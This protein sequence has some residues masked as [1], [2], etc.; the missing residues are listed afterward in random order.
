MLRDASFFKIN[1][2][3]GIKNPLAGPFTYEYFNIGFADSDGYA[4][5]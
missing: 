1:I 2:L 5:N 3:S 4:I